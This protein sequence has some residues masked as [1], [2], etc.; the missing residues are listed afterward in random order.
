ML[1]ER[2]PKP[3]HQKRLRK[4]SQRTA[5]NAKAGS[6]ISTAEAQIF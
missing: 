5:F 3:T 6:Q 2:R 1:K 4:I